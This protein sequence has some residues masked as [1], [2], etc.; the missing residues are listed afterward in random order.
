M[1]TKKPFEGKHI[2]LAMPQR[3]DIYLLM[4]KNL[5]ALGFKVTDVSFQDEYFTYKNLKEKIN[6]FYRKTILKDRGYK[7]TLKFRHQKATI[8]DRLQEISS[9]ADFALMIRPDLYPE[10]IIQLIKEK[11]EFLIGYQWD[12]L[13]RF[14]KVK[15]QIPLFDRFFVFDPDDTSYPNVQGITNFWL[16]FGQGKAEV[17]PTT[18]LFFL[19]IY[20]EN[21]MDYIFDFVNKI[22][23]LPIKSKIEIYTDS[24]K[25]LR[26]KNPAIRFVHAK[27]TYEELL[28]ENLDSRILVDF[29]STDHTGLSFRLFEALGSERKLITNNK[30]IEKYDA[31]MPENVLIYNTETS[32]ESIY[33]FIA[34]PQKEI[35]GWIKEK[36][37]FRNWMMN[38]TGHPD[39]IPIKLPD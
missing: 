21:R 29:V 34:A 7:T 37:S 25:S 39:A 18:D 33:R 16:D 30:E 26:S 4:I 22:T 28:L 8:E 35:P 9:K 1:D 23:A 12:G 3:Y 20:V 31:Y 17:V 2:I 36:Y 15:E 27:R 24:E 38:V 32:A 6:N 11:S 14:P 5:E 19:G 10:R 13:N